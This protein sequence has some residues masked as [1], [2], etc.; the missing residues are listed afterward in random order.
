MARKARPIDTRTAE[1]LRCARHPLRPV[2]QNE[3]RWQGIE[4]RP[5]AVYIADHALL[6]ICAAAGSD[7]RDPSDFD[8]QNAQLAALIVA[9]SIRWPRGREVR[10]L[11]QYEEGMNV[12]VSVSLQGLSERIAD[13]LSRLRL[14]SPPQRLP[15]AVVTYLIGFIR[16]VR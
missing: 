13:C 16:R 14:P 10:A 7:P 4:C 12:E 8:R 11:L 2:T 6:V 1:M 3:F 15:N 9:R 5:T